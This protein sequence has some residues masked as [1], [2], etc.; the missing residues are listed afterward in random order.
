MI[1]ECWRFP[2]AS[3]WSALACAGSEQVEA[4][5]SQVPQLWS[6][7]CQDMGFPGVRKSGNYQHA[8]GYEILAAQLWHPE[9][10]ACWWERPGGCNLFHSFPPALLQ[11]KMPMGQRCHAVKTY[12]CFSH[13]FSIPESILQY[14]VWFL[15]ICL[16]FSR[17]LSISK[18]IL[19][20]VL[21]TK[22]SP[23]MWISRYMMPCDGMV[24]HPRLKSL[25][26]PVY[27]VPWRGS[28]ST[29]WMNE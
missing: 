17:S 12:R 3:H 10:L 15:Y 14:F 9:T 1:V 21:A 6:F 29:K 8:L 28:L 18:N 4:L 23:Y 27:R 20:D 26:C 22:N 19:K 16:F 24:L 13:K 5:Y 7:H 11:A 2:D 25:P